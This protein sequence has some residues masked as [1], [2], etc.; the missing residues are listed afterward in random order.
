MLHEREPWGTRIIRRC[1]L[2]NRKERALFDVAPLTSRKERALSY[3]ARWS[4]LEIEE[5]R[6]LKFYAEVPKVRP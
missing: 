1:P 2:T 3:V 6:E 5:M 4:K